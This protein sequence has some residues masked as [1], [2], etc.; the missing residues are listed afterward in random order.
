MSET[1]NFC[2][3]KG[4][5]GCS[6][7]VSAKGLTEEEHALLNTRLPT[8]LSPEE[9]RRK[10]AEYQDVIDDLMVRMGKANGK[11]ELA[12]RMVLVR[13]LGCLR[14]RIALFPTLR[15]ST[16]HLAEKHKLSELVYRLAGEFNLM[17]LSAAAG[18]RTFCFPNLVRGLLKTGKMEGQSI[19]R[20]IDTFEFLKTM[21]LHPLDSEMVQSQLKRTIELHARYK[22][23]LTHSPAMRDFRKYIAANMFYIGPAMRQDLTPLE[24]HAICGITVLVEEQ[25]GHTI[26]T[27]VQELENF[28]FDYEA[29]EMFDVADDTPLRQ[30]AIAIARASKVALDDI[31]TINPD[32]IHGYVPYRVK[33]IL[34]I[35]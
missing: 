9:T 18:Y 4:N 28:I 24:R 33:R 29:S 35:D 21:F 22:V 32:R 13:N 12:A 7:S 2:C 23:A 3:C 30:K 27:T 11:L 19:K 16:M 31:P 15:R 8:G 14:T 17:E 5:F 25:M 10:W 1:T 26:E 20:M 6:C 34:A